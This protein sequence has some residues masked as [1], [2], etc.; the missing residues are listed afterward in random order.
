[1]GNLS[2]LKF[3]LPRMSDLDS[4]NLDTELIQIKRMANSGVIPSGERLKAFAV[5][6]H[7]KKEL[8]KIDEMIGCLIG[9]C[10]LEEEQVVETSSD[11]KEVLLIADL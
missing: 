9:I 11:L 6:C 1:V 10:K 2:G 7:Q 8:G 3:N 4:I 5:A